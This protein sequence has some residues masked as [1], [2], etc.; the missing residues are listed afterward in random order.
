MESIWQD[1]RLSLRSLRRQPAFAAVA[2]LTLALSTGVSAALFSVIDATILHPLPYPRPEQLVEIRVEHRLPDGRESRYAPS[3]EDVRAWNA[4]NAGFQHIAIERSVFPTAIF[5]AGTPERAE[6]V[7]V[8]EEY[9]PL[10]GISPVRGRLFTAADMVWKAP[11][12]VLI[13]HAFWNSRFAADASVIGR[14]VRV[15][16]EPAEIIG[17]LP[18]GFGDKMPL[19]RALQVEPERVRN[20]GSG[21]S[22]RGRLVDATDA[23]TAAT[24]LSA[25]LP[26]PTGAAKNDQASVRFLLDEVRGDYRTI[27]T[28]LAGAVGVILLLAC[29]NVGGL[30]LARGTARHAELAVRASLGAGRGRL[31]RQVLTESLVLAAVGGL[32]GVALAWITLDA[33][34][35]NLPTTLP[36]NAPA[37]ISGIVLAAMIATTTL[38]GLLFGLIPA[39]R[40]SR[41]RLGQVLARAGRQHASALSRRGG[42]ALIAIEVALAVVMVAGAG[43]M[44]RSFSRLIAVDLGFDPSRML[45]VEVQPISPQHTVYASYYPALVEAVRRLPGVEAAGAGDSGPLGALG[46]L[47]SYG[48]ARKPN[49]QEEMVVRRTVMSGYVEAL[50]IPVVAGRALTEA[51]ERPGPSVVLINQAA[52]RKLFGEASPLGQSLELF[53]TRAQVVGVIADVR[54]SG[55]RWPGEVEVLQVYRPDEASKADL[56]YPPRPLIL[57]VRPRAAAPNLAEDLRRV[58]TTLGPPVVFDGVRRG[59]DMFGE[60]INRQRQRTVLLGLLGALGLT[61]AVVGVLGM[62]SYAVGRRTQEIGVRLAFGAQPGQ[63]VRAM[64]LDSALPIVVGLVLG[65]G[66]AYLS[67]NVIKSFLFE[68]SPTD[69]VTLAA[70][71]ATLGVVGCAAAWIPSRRA[72]R[73]DPVA[74][75]RSE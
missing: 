69:P 11:G 10:Y 14:V 62:T 55:P 12:V 1:I 46:G 43:L 58:A 75:L 5:D 52:A 70:V 29:V 72:A 67:T 48:S 38:T 36:D 34:V 4:A 59:A 21:W 60:T 16:G 31:L 54:V 44:I 2:I 6:S 13:S 51:D 9:F 19:W 68:T 8:S 64:L 50:G 63:V 28:I 25:A 66:A 57:A 7:K 15:D 24:R 30:L 56:K 53:K 45:V 37:R 22:V 17:V 27:V 47:T 39:L 35:A 18:R 32:A 3:L 74:T 33:I 61:L 23:K 49:G 73:V 26:G 65:T 40:L 42:Q 20:R 41:V 71:A